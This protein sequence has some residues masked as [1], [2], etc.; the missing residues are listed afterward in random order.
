MVWLAVWMLLWPYILLA[1][2]ICNWGINNTFHCQDCVVYCYLDF[3]YG[4]MYSIVHSRLTKY[5]YASFPSLLSFQSWFD[6]AK[7]GGG[8]DEV[9]EK[10]IAQE[11]EQHV[12]RTL[13]Q[14]RPVGAYQCSNLVVHTLLTM[15]ETT[16]GM[17]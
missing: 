12:L 3:A 11:R 4:C 9:R 5:N 10:I 13:H 14:V 15:H 2:A 7:G 8:E 1:V 16:V 6:F 17:R